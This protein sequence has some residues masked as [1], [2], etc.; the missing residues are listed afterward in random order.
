MEEELGKPP[1]VRQ[2]SG[3]VDF[4][5]RKRHGVEKNAPRLLW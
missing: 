1:Q 5:E 4:V 3:G 2:N